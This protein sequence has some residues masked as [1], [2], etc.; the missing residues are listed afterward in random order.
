MGAGIPVSQL[1]FH[2]NGSSERLSNL[3]RVT[4]LLQSRTGLLQSDSE[5]SYHSMLSMQQPGERQKLPWPLS[6][7]VL[8]PG[9]EKTPL[10]HFSRQAAIWII[11]TLPSPKAMGSL[12]IRIMAIMA[13]SNETERPCWGP[14]LEAAA[15]PPMCRE[16]CQL[17]PFLP[18]LPLLL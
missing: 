4:Q 2:S 7:L 12:S 6:F 15:Q 11:L 1:S 18:E 16:T 10:S 8:Y 17:K 3:P 13:E 9:W 14:I 5:F